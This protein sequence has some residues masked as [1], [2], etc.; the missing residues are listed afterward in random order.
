MYRTI[1]VPVDI[2]NSEHAAAMLETAAKLGDPS[3]KIVLLYVIETV[4][5]YVAVHMPEDY[6]EKL[7]AEAR[8][9]LRRIA[10]ST[11]LATETEIRT[12]HAA[13]EILA[14]ADEK[15][16]DAII[17]ASHRPGFEDYFLGSTAARVVRHAK[18]SV[19]VIR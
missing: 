3:T 1:V 14:V 18:C 4:P 10:Q 15:K 5:R 2:S 16:A 17:I 13:P 9:A 6:S 12:G 11:S 19:V 8:E 7:I